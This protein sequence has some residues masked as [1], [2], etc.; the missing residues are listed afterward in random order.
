MGDSLVALSSD[1]LVAKAL[2]T[3]DGATLP[4]VNGISGSSVAM[5][6][7]APRII[8]I[9]ERVKLDYAFVSLGSNDMANG[10]TPVQSTVT[11]N[12][13]KVMEA[14]DS[15]V[16]VYW[17]LPSHAQQPVYV[18][19][20]RAALKDAARG[21]SNVVM[22]DFEAY[23]RTQGL[24]LSDVLGADGIHWNATGEQQYGE[25]FNKLRGH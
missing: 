25:F 17:V 21:F 6:Y 22:V 5:P 4:V 2:N 18:P 1:M 10:T 12:A 16:T 7:W 8:N 13:I 23:L 14:F 24:E 20:V 19:M 9:Q 3:T 15:D 11:A